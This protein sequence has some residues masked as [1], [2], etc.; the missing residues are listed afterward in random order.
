MSDFQL[1]TLPESS[2]VLIGLL[3]TIFGLTFRD[4]VGITSLFTALGIGLL[5]A[6]TVYVAAKGSEWTR[7]TLVFVSLVAVQL[8]AFG[9]VVRWIGG[10]MIGTVVTVIAYSRLPE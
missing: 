10:V 4:S 9:G 8:I 6:G 3:F 5:I 7:L 2:I 1:T